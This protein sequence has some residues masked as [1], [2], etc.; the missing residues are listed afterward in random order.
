MRKLIQRNHCLDRLVKFGLFPEAQKEVDSLVQWAKGILLNS[1]ELAEFQMTDTME[2]H[3]LA[4]LSN[5]QMEDYINI[6]AASDPNGPIAR[7]FLLGMFA[8]WPETHQHLEQETPGVVTSPAGRALLRELYEDIKG[9]CSGARERHT[10]WQVLHA[11]QTA[12]ERANI[13]REMDEEAGNVPP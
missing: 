4:L 11:A 8:L 7:V 10:P 9:F 13:Y 2:P 6:I 5:E 1:P 12:I 3:M